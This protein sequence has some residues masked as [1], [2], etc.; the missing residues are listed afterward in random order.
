MSSAECKFLKGGGRTMLKVLA[1]EWKD[2]SALPRS[3][4]R[5]ARHTLHAV[6]TPVTMVT[7]KLFGVLCFFNSQKRGKQNCERGKKMYVGIQIVNQTK[8]KKRERKRKRYWQVDRR[9]HEQK[10]AKVKNAMKEIE[11]AVK[12]CPCAPATQGERS[13]ARKGEVETRRKRAMYR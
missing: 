8:R 10:K 2:T 3:Y 1:T 12:Q 4:H 9:E 5:I 6:V 13:W 11:R 7:Q